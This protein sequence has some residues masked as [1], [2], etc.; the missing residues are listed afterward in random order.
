MFLYRPPEDGLMVALV[1]DHRE[2]AAIPTD[3]VVT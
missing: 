1:L 2:V 3:G